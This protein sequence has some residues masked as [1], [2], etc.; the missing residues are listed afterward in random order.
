MPTLEEVLRQKRGELQ[1]LQKEVDTLEEAARIV[2]RQQA[3]KPVTVAPGR[4]L[5]QPLMARAVLLEA[6]REMH[7]KEIS[8]GIKD[9]FGVEISPNYVAPVLYRQIGSMFYKSEKAPNTFGLPEWK[10]KPEIPAPFNNPNMEIT[11]TPDGSIIARHVLT[12]S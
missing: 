12:G 5:S 7:V 4:K 2:A 1:A 8:K 11:R 6:R 10:N 9:K 3:A